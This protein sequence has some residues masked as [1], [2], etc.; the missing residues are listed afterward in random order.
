MTKE[1]IKAIG[2]WSSDAVEKYMRGAEAI[3]VRASG[4]MGF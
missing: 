1:Q 2:G 3:Q 4:C